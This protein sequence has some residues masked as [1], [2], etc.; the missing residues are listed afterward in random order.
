[1]WKLTVSR[2]WDEVDDPAFLGEWLI[3]MKDSSLQHV[4]FHPVILKTW[5][6]V[7]RSVYD[8]K[9]FYLIAERDDVRFFLPLMI[10]RKNWKNAF[11]KLLVPVGY[12][13]YDYHDPIVK[14][15]VSEKIVASF[16]SL[17]RDTIQR[18]VKYDE[19][20][21]CGMH[22]SSGQDGWVPED[23]S[24]YCNLR[25]YPDFSSFFLRLKKSFRKDI[26]RQERRLAELGQISFKVFG[27]NESEK[28]QLVFPDFLEAH[29]RKWPNA[30]KPIG[31]HE[32]LL[33]KG[34]SAGI[35]H[36]SMIEVGG[37]PISWHFGFNY[38]R[39]FYYYMPAFLEKYGSFSPGKLHLSF[40]MK[41][42]FSGELEVFDFLR[43]AEAYKKDWTNAEEILY[44]FLL[45]G[46]G[47]SSTVKLFFNN[48]LTAMKR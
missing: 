45:S 37:N 25:D 41:D 29:R 27:R 7:F 31:F 35:V 46:R 10:W 48:V 1:M 23:V 5:S 38:N 4:F 43:G 22:F 2:S 9:P 6:D 19:A 8:I 24:P 20:F 16:W 40:L 14:G 36:F 30:F 44:S 26:E 15:N 13:D 39:R 21:I 17:V 3:L 47:F 33:Q 32:K 12:P 34:L 11:I 28:A 42:A 18:E